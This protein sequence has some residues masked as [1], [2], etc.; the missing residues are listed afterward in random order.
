M[1]ESAAGWAM[2]V[3]LA[4]GA[5]AGAQGK[6]AAV[7]NGEPIPMAEVDA[8]MAMRP[9]ELFPVPQQQKR[10]LQQEVLDGLVSERLMRQYLA[11]HGPAIDPAEVDRQMAALAESQKAAGKTLA[12][13]CR[14]SHQT[15]AQVRASVQNMLQFSAFARSR[16]TDEELKKYFTANLEYF[17]KVTVRC[18]HI[19]IRVPLGASEAERQESRK[20]LTQIRQKLV[21]MQIGFADAAREYSQCPS[22]PKGGDIGFIT[23]K[24]MVD[25]PVAK[26]AF[27]LKKGEMSELVESEF[28]L[29]L[30]YVTDRTEPKP[31][32]F[33]ACIDDVR[34]CFVEELRQTLLVELR[35]TAKIEIKLQ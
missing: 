16:A 7:V 4:V 20:T 18:S 24:W 12:D 6:V 14:E 9:P 27:A 28:G 31:T 17:Q 23:R 29:H 33:V 15:E 22:A 10:Q 2:A 19:V 30:I 8:V 5:R 35:K 3:A 1:R 32:E 34:D 25:E 21:A 11:K 13:F 26:A